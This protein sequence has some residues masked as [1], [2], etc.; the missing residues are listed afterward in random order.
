MSIQNKG[1]RRL[2]MVSFAGL[3]LLL[4]FLCCTAFVRTMKNTKEIPKAELKLLKEKETI[5]KD[6][7]DLSKALCRFDNSKRADERTA[8]QNQADA[9]NKKID[10]YQEVLKKDTARIYND[11]ISFMQ[12][13]DQY[14]Y[15]I[16]QMGKE[17][18]ERMKVCNLE[19]TN[20]RTQNEALL[21]EK[22]QL[23]LDILKKENEKAGLLVDLK[24]AKVP[25]SSGGGSAP[26]IPTTTKNCAPEVNAYKSEIKLSIAKLKEDIRNIKTGV[27]DISVSIIG[28][29]KKINSKKK[30]I[31]ASI[32]QLEQK[33]DVLLEK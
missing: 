17:S 8:H 18:D 23:Q 31:K 29:K 13:A 3:F 7:A 27:D 2:S 24:S 4:L 9:K 5:L 33:I 21:N 1:N 11:V 20:L 26:V 12:M 10:L 19:L 28:N 16:D 14:Y 22:N 32:T 15:L 30:T 6:F 25:K